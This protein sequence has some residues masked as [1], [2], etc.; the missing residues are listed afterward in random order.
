MSSKGT[1]DAYIQQNCRK[2]ENI[3]QRKTNTETEQIKALDHCE[4]RGF[5]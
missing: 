4:I 2:K 1:E 5:F 3:M